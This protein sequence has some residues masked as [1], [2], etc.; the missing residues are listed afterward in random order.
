MSGYSSAYEFRA[1][2]AL[3]LAID[4]VFIFKVLH[5]DDIMVL[6]KAT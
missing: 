4:E 3:Q 2:L 1:N 6:L 5:Q